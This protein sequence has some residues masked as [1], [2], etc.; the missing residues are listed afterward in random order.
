MKKLLLLLTVGCSGDVTEYGAHVRTIHCVGDAFGV[1][2]EYRLVQ[3]TGITEGDAYL[4]PYDSP[5]VYIPVG[6]D[7]VAEWGEWRMLPVENP[8]RLAVFRGEQRAFV[9][10]CSE[11]VMS[12]PVPGRPGDP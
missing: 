7:G 1:S 10:N 11:G 9:R 3:W 4:R 12:M 8:L 5:Q 2:A 6:D